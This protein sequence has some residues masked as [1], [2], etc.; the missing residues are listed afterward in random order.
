[1]RAAGFFVLAL[2]ACSTNNH[3]LSANVAE[4]AQAAAAADGVYLPPTGSNQIF[5]EVTAAAPGHELIV[6]DLNLPANAVG[7]RH[8]HP[9]EEYLYVIAGS[10]VVDMDGADARLLRAGESFIIPRETVHT[11]RAGP[12]GVRAIVVRVHDL[13]DPVMIPAPR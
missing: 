3:P 5:R 6:A 1:M 7:E 4:E 8:Y 12:Q 13:G 10:A 11:P 9:W 2:A